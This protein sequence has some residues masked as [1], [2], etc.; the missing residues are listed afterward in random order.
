MKNELYDHIDKVKKSREEQ[1]ADFK[2]IESWANP[3]CPLCFGRGWSG[4]HVEL[5]QLI[6]CNGDKCLLD[7]LKKAY[8]AG[9]PID[10]S[11]GFINKFRQIFGMGVNN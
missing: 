3:A 11:E 9:D 8:I 4:W 1:E 7:N 6:P 10:E 5:E 2:K